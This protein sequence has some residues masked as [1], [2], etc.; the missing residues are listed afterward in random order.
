MVRLGVDMLHH[1]A[2]QAG[3]GVF[4]AAK[5]NP[6]VYVFGSN[7]DQ[8]GLAPDRVIGSAVIDLPRAFLLI[9]REVR[10]GKFHPRVESFGLESG[11]IRY[12]TNPALDTLVSAALKAKVQAAQDS[13][14]AGTLVPV[15]AT[16]NE[17][18]AYERKLRRQ[19]WGAML[20]GGA[21]LV[22]ALVVGVKLLA[23]Q[24]SSSFNGLEV[25]NSGTIGRLVVAVD[26]SM[27]TID[28]SRESRVASGPPLIIVH[29]G[30]F[31]DGLR[32]RYGTA[33]PAAPG[34]AR[35]RHGALR[36]HPLDVHPAIGTTS[37]SRAN[38]ASPTWLVRQ[39]QGYRWAWPEISRFRAKA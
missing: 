17:V 2:D 34:I 29:H 23:F 28:A 4:Q 15:D 7:A 22:S 11:V 31:W 33:L 1:N 27:A 35:E 13:I 37:C 16:R 24:T 3:L 38:Q 5:E 6:G 36:A 12:V 30:L 10:E 20:S 18:E 9:A 19:K 21:A 26:A 14:I 32:T 8:T 25:E 39:L